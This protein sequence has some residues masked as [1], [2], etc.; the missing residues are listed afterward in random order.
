MAYLVRL[1][2]SIC[3]GVDQAERNEAWAFSDFSITQ[4][5]MPAHRRPKPCTSSN[6]YSFMA[7]MSSA[8]CHPASRCN[9]GLPSKCDA[10]CAKAVFQFNHKCKRYMRNVPVSF[11]PGQLPECTAVEIQQLNE[12]IR[13]H[14]SLSGLVSVVLVLWCGRE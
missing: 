12:C 11:E 8:C 5:K 7:S 3:A 1:S 13:I 10:R 6:F 14:L 2:A 4:R 9:G